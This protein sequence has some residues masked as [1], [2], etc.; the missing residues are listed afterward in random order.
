[1]PADLFDPASRP[2]SAR[3]SRRLTLF[4]S[5]ALHAVALVVFL[6]GP[7]AGAVGLPPLMAR[8]DS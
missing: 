2:V 1:M 3:S 5:I 8:I 6:L 7:L 4:T